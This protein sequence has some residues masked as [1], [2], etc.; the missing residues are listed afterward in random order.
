MA[1]TETGKRKE[2]TGILAQLRKEGM[3]ASPVPG[4]LEH[5][6]ENGQELD[7]NEPGITPEERKRRLALQRQSVAATPAPAQPGQVSPLPGA[8]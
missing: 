3:P 2:V 8:Y 1:L 4:G 6:D 7:P 5:P